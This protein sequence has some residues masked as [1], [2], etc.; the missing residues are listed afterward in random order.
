LHQRIKLAEEWFLDIFSTNCDAI[1]CDEKGV[2]EKEI[3]LLDKL[4]K[5]FTFT[6]YFCEKH[7]D[8]ASTQWDNRLISQ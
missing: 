8:E 1:D 4:N 5:P 7:K 6:A 2:Y 3:T